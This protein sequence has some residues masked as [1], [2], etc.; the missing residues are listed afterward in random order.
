MTKSLS[1][2]FVLFLLSPANGM[3][4]SWTD[5]AGIAHYTNKEYEIPLRYRA[6]VKA[7]YPEPGD[8]T[9]PLQNP[10]APQV[11]QSEQTQPQARALPAN[12]PVPANAIADQT[13]QLLK[14]ERE[15]RKASRRNRDADED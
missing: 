14:K 11:Q 1:V 5:S 12:H 9:V 7:R 15:A 8:S 6:K 10:Q 3:V 13:I 4:Y 2:L